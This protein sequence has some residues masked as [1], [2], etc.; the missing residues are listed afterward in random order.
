MSLRNAVAETVPAAVSPG[1]V[2]NSPASA[3]SSDI[4]CAIRFMAVYLS[5][6]DSGAM[7]NDLLIAKPRPRKEESCC[8]GP[9]APAAPAR[10]L[11][12][13][14]ILG[15]ADAKDGSKLP[16]ADQAFFRSR[17]ACARLNRG[18]AIS[19]RRCE[20]SDRCARQRSGSAD[21]LLA[22]AAGWPWGGT[23]PAPCRPSGARY[24]RRARSI[25]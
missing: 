17:V 10:L 18:R 6:R 11:N 21:A 1:V 12:R 20:T 13:R 2:T 22:E 15:V 5:L 8:H 9:I 25:P 14:S 24:G 16:P 3:N 19:F 4:N 7:N 23:P